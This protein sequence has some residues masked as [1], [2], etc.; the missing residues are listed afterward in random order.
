M[1]ALRRLPVRIRLALISASL[2]FAILLLF[3]VVIG[4]FAGR[5]VRSEFDDELRVTAADLQ[6]KLP[7]QPPLTGPGIQGDRAAIEAGAAGPPATQMLRLAGPNH[8]AG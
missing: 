5:Q 7:V 8:H 1:R 6:Q 3:A 2:T 4:V